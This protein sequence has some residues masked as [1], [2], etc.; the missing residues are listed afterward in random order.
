MAELSPFELRRMLALRRFPVISEA[1]LAELAMLAE[2]VTEVTLPAGTVVAT[3][4][5][6]LPAVHLV[7]HGEIASAG[8]HPRTWRD[9]QVFGGLEVLAHREAGEAA[10]TTTE[11]TTLQLLESDAIDVLEDSFGVLLAVL[12]GLAAHT[13]RRLARPPG[14]AQASTRPF[15]LVERLMALRQ[16]PMFAKA[17]MDALVA[18][19]HSSE[20]IARAAG[21]VMVRAGDASA[22]AWVVLEG[23]LRAT[24][25]G[26]ARPLGPGD[27]VGLVEALGELAHGETVEASTAVRVVELATTNLFDVIEDHTDFG[28]SIIAV[29]AGELADSLAGLPLTN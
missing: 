29:L 1:E 21:T 4:G 11:T 23:A 10:V 22:G 6:R 5:R 3:A 19:S 14:P 18:L 26:G 17:P 13:T 12:R 16:Q 27:V 2:N 20:E 28:R 15:G 9:G 7:L 24:G 8:L 25:G